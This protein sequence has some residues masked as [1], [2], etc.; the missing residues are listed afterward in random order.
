M[1]KRLMMAIMMAAM[2]TLAATAQ[3]NEMYIED[4]TIDPGTVIEVPVMLHCQTPSRGM[5]FDLTLCE[6]LTLQ[7]IELTQE[8]LDKGMNL[9]TRRG[10]NKV[11]IGTYPSNRVCYDTVP[12]P[13]VI[14]YLEAAETFTGGTIT[15]TRVRGA[16]LDNASIKM[17]DTTTTVTAGGT[18]GVAQVVVPRNAV[19]V[20][21]FTLDGIRVTRPAGVAIQVT[22][23]DDGT[24]A[25]CKIRE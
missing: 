23:Y 6:G 24:T 13:V 15:M 2:L 5:Q 12:T 17:N 14:L 11:T 3:I 16:T 25:A 18:S 22:R 7:D 9:F 10:G 4:F 19:G 21:Y 1:T 20:D 8:S